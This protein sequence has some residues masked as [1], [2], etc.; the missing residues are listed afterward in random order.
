M[1]TT[2][3]TL[4]V[5][6]RP[7]GTGIPGLTATLVKRTDEVAW[8][9]RSDHYHEVFLIKT[10]RTFDRT[11]MMEYYPGTND[12]GKTAWCTGDDHKAARY[13]ANLCLGKPIDE[14]I[15]PETYKDTTHSQK[16]KIRRSLY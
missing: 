9:L 8:Y 15:A 3:K 14:R 13:F 1:E 4:P 16:C 7:K 6:V 12:F 10:G 11:G 5:T 2:I